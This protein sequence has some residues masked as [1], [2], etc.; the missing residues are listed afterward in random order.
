MPCRISLDAF[1][2]LT[3]QHGNT[4]QNESGLLRAAATVFQLL[5]IVGWRCFR[6]SFCAS[7]LARQAIDWHTITLS[8]LMLLTKGAL[9]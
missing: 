9:S 4:P 1:W 3:Q 6:C 5:I 7:R 8:G 2:P